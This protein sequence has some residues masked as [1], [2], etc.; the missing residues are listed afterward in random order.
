MTTG[1][2]IRAVAEI[3]RSLEGFFDTNFPG[4][5]HRVLGNDAIKVVL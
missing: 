4:S 3:S 5:M 1:V 2:D